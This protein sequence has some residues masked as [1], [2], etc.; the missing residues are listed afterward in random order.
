MYQLRKGQEKVERG[1]LS[2]YMVMVG[3]LKV[4]NAVERLQKLCV[5]QGSSEEDL[6]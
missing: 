4:D 2:L 3:L 6:H 5:V 1:W